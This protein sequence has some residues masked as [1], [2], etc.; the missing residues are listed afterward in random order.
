MVVTDTVTIAL[1]EN[2]APIDAD[3][4]ARLK[5]AIASGEYG[6]DIDALVEAMIGFG[7]TD[8]SNF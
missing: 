3:K 8:P 6:V 4:V 1:L 2:D 7:R 5:A